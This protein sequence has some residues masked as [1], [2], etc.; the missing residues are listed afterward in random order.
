MELNH[1]L[2]SSTDYYHQHQTSD[3]TRSFK[4]SFC[5]RGFSNAQALGGHMNIHRK[6]RAKLRQL[7]NPHDHD[8]DHNEIH[9]QQEHQEHSYN[10]IRR[11]K[12]SNNKSIET[13]HHQFQEQGPSFIEASQW[14]SGCSG[15]GGSVEDYDEED[16]FPKLD[17]EL[18]LGPEPVDHRMDACLGTRNFF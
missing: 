11:L 2:S 16:M 18:R 7:S 8:H 15:R 6:D 1:Q 14:A 13:N 4:C 3:I 17:L 12:K 5:N 10:R 9:I